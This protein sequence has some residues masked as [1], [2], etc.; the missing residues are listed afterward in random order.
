MNNYTEDN[1]ITVPKANVTPGDIAVK[2]GDKIFICRT[3]ASDSFYKCDS[4]D[5][6]NKTWTGYK[7]VL[8]DEG[9]SFEETLTE[10]LTYDSALT[11]PAPKG[12][13]NDGALVQVSK[14]YRRSFIPDNGLVFYAPLH[15]SFDDI[16]GGAATKSTYGTFVVYQGYPCVKSDGSSIPARWLNP[17]SFPLSKDTMSMFCMFNRQYR[18]DWDSMMVLCNN[19]GIT[20]FG[21]RL[22][23]GVLYHYDGVEIKKDGASFYIPSDEWHTYALTRVEGVYYVYYDGELINTYV[24]EFNSVD[25]QQIAVGWFPDTSAKSDGYF[26]DLMLYNRPLSA[27]EVKAIHN[28]MMGA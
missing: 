8:S 18:T 27:E 23:K 6:K 7:A 15:D 4:V 1:L 10:G 2:I 22:Y 11:P 20:S 26:S 3:S 25:S 16:V 28:T 5:K 12:I 21:L 19:M 24:K 9:Y 13:Y 14:L 17:G